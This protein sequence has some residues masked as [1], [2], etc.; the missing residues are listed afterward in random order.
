MQESHLEVPKA[1]E[2]EVLGQR[3]VHNKLHLPSVHLNH[4]HVIIVYNYY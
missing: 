4:H 3:R 2:V 1:G